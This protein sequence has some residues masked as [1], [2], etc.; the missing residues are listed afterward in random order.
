MGS[1]LRINDEEY[2]LKSAS[3][4]FADIIKEIQDRQNE[5]NFIEDY[6]DGGWKINKKGIA[7]ILL[8]VNTLLKPNNNYEILDNFIEYNK[9]KYYD[10]TT[11]EDYII[12][13]EWFRNV[14]VSGLCEMLLYDKRK[15][16]V[17]W[18]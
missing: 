13:L 14:L 17:T 9:D 6:G 2:N 5:D 8:N 1:Y 7:I 12:Y 3:F 11:K 18:I 10:D 4:L 15:I 16:Y